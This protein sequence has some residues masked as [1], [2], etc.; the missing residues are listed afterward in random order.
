TESRVRSPNAKNTLATAVSDAFDIALQVLRLRGPT[1]LVHAERAFAS[2]RGHTLEPRFDNREQRSSR[3]GL[4]AELDERRRLVLRVDL[5]VDPV[6]DPAKAEVALGLNALDG[7]E[8]RTGV[9]HLHRRRGQTGALLCVDNNGF[10]ELLVEH[11]GDRRTGNET[12][13][14]PNA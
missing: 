3:S 12:A 11:A 9:G 2:T 5:S 7:A 14:E 4:E 6:R 8:H 13:L 1:A 10:V